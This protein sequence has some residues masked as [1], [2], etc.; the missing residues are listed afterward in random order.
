MLA[1]SCLFMVMDDV[2]C[3]LVWFMLSYVISGVVA[4]SLVL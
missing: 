1:I 4:L 3:V 2:G